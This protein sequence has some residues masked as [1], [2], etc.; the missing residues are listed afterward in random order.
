MK[1]PFRVAILAIVSLLVLAYFA[2]N[3]VTVPAG[4]VGV[5]VAMYGDDKG[6]ITVVGNGRY[7]L[8]INEQMFN[9]PTYTQTV[10]WEG[11]NSLRMQ[12]SD[13][14]SIGA[15]VGLTYQVDPGKAGDLFRKYRL[16]LDEIT[17]VHL[18]TM[19]RNALNLETSR[20]KVEQIYSG[21]REDLLL[22]A[23]QRV[24]EQVAP[25]GI[26][27]ENLYLLGELDLPATTVEAINRKV[28][29]DQ[30]A[31]QAKREVLRAEELA[32][33]VVKQAEGQAKA[34]QLAADADAHA[35][36]V[37]GAALRAN[38]G[39]IEYTKAQRWDGVL[40]R[41]TGGGTPILDLR[42]DK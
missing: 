11:K 34:R 15:A 31:D 26:L 6:A 24:R 30:R 39:V 42:S 22:L 29:A 28:E 12:D 27:V 35:I 13:G 37:M 38:P 4:Q 19:V 25:V 16:G 21:K 18:K 7:L 20:L 5:R 3:W 32:N 1:H 36:E 41:V 23:L 17:N 40:P 14:Q 8:G 10:A 2:V 33:A 9:F